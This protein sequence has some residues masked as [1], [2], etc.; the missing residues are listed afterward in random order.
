MTDVSSVL[1]QVGGHLPSVT[2]AVSMVEPRRLRQFSLDLANTSLSEA[3][4]H[5]T[6]CNTETLHRRRLRLVEEI[7]DHRLFDAVAA[8]SK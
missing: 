3:S 7:D 6:L 4:S 8:G 5:T 1:S 2:R